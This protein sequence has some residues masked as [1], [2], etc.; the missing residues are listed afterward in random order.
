[1]EGADAVLIG[2]LRLH[3]GV[4]EA[5]EQRLYADRGQQPADRTGGSIARLDPVAIGSRLGRDAF[6]ADLVEGEIP[7]PVEC[8]A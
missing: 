7:F 3:V 8:V 2:Q 4:G 5:G 6:I 1:M